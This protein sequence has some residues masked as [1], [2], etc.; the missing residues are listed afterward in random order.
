MPN[1]V[2]EPPVAA[3]TQVTLSPVVVGEAMTKNGS[4]L[5]VAPA[6]LVTLTE[7]WPE[8]GAVLGITKVTWVAVTPVGV[9]AAEPKF[10]LVVVDRAV[11]LIWTVSP[12][13]PWLV[14]VAVSTNDVMVA[15]IF[16]LEVAALP[17]AQEQAVS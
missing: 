15:M 10:T 1:S 8:H 7:T 11:P 13:L 4:A 14:V 9:T 16:L 5:L 2:T 3:D 12:G 6:L 17:G